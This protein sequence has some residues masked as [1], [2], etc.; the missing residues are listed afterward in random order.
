MVEALLA[1]KADVNARDAGGATPLHLAAAQG[2]KSVAEVL[3]AAKADVNAR[4]QRGDTPL[5]MAAA[6]GQTALVDLL[7]AHKAEVNIRITAPIQDNPN[8]GAS[9][10]GHAATPLI[11]AILGNHVAVVKLLLTAKAEVNFECQTI[12]LGRQGTQWVSPLHLAVEV[13]SPEIIR[14]LLDH[15]ANPNAQVSASG[16]IAAGTTPLLVAVLRGKQEIAQLLLAHKADP[17]LP[18]GEGKTPLH[19]AVLE[20]R[21]DLVELLLANHAEVNRQDQSGKTPLGYAVGLP[22]T[23]IAA[24]LLD[25]KA[26]PNLKDNRG[27]TPLF[28]AT[29][30][31]EEMVEL[32]LAKGASPNIRDNFGNTPLVLAKASTNRSMPGRPGLPSPGFPL[33]PMP[34]QAAP[35]PSEIVKLLRQHGAIEEL[36]RMDVIEVRRPSANFSEVVFTKG[37]NDYNHFTLFEAIAAHY[38]FVTARPSIVPGQTYEMSPWR[39]QGSL[40]FPDLR[41]ITVHHPTEDGLNWTV[42][43]FNLG[44]AFQPLGFQYVGEQ[45]AWGD[46][47]EIP[48]ADHPIN[49]VWQGLPDEM[50]ANLKQR[51]DRHVQLTVKGQT[52]NLLLSLQTTAPPWARDRRGSMIGPVTPPTFL[53]QPVLYGSGLLRASSDLSR[54]KVKRRDA[55]TGQ[56]YELLFDC[57]GERPGP[58]F[59]LQNGDAIEVPEKP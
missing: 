55:A 42:I 40:A 14:L 1:A 56:I 22:E 29:Q 39:R 35:G 25:A 13:N 49:A 9:Q 58:D 26:N 11:G 33:Q 6:A 31:R 41:S 3:L 50:L 43:H 38:G 23:G 59:W 12:A 36:P 32:L 4:D 19:R 20:D 15:G 17:S 44:E 54:V 27:Q 47:V 46:V 51:V 21:K 48:E 34:G 24:A 7:L 8:P 10:G 53:L 2:F 16:G 30:G 5:H 52:T 45:L 57:S 37:T 18:D 28:Y